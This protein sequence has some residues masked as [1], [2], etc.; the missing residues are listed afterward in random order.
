MARYAVPSWSRRA[1]SIHTAFILRG[2]IYGLVWTDNVLDERRGSAE[3]C[4]AKVCGTT[5]WY[6]GL[7]ADIAVARIFG[8]YG[9][10]Y[11]I[12]DEEANLGD[13]YGNEGESW[14]KRTVRLIP[15]VL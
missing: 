12:R 5:G 6:M 15:G 7:V 13:A 8:A 1:I 3:V 10:F 9:T 4:L 11:R 14:H 2:I